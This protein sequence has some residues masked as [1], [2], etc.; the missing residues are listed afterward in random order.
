MRPLRHRW[1]WIDWLILVLLLA[2][3][4]AAWRAYSEIRG[5]FYGW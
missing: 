4:V 5:A 3:S 1:D 2:T